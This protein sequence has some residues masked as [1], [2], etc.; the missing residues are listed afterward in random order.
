MRVQ[1]HTDFLPYLLNRVVS[2]LNAPMQKM[3]QK[4]AM[5]LT[6]WRILGILSQEDRLTISALAELSVTDQATLSRAL[7]RLEQRQMIR[8]QADT[9]DSRQFRVTLLAR[10]RKEYREISAYAQQVQAWAFREMSGP[11]R[12]RLRQ[13][14][15][16]LDDS[17]TA[18]DDIANVRVKEVI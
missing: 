13:M 16:A 7:D 17:M 9:D 14:L 12:T 4:R 10:G 15:L 18:D 8:R 6:H 5:T 2:Q 1:R 3:L 11:D